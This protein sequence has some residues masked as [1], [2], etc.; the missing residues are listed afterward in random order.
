MNATNYL[1]T[2]MYSPSA[3]Q[4]IVHHQTGKSNLQETQNLYWRCVFCLFESSHRNNKDTF[5]HLLYVNKMPPATIDG[6]STVDLIRT[7]NIDVRM[8]DE[9][10]LP[11][12]GYYKAWS[13]QFVLL[14]ILR[15]MQQFVES[16][17][18]VVI[19]DSDV[20]FS[21]PVQ[22]DFFNDIDKYNSLLYTIDYP[23]QR[24]VNGVSL[25]EL[26]TMVTELSP[27]NTNSLYCEGGELICFKGA[28]LSR[29]LNTVNAGYQWSLARFEKGL[30][31]FNTEEH[32]FSYSYWKL[33]LQPFTGNKYLKRMWTDLSSAVNLEPGDERR[34]LWHLPAEKKHG[35]V[36]YFRLMGKNGNS[37][38]GHEQSLATMFRVNPSIRDRFAMMAR[39]PLK[40]TYKLIKAL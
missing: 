10:S 17:D 18:R 15:Q 13:S 36:R 40:K 23:V 16:H 26:R 39:I 3:E 5:K 38:A 14:D 19:L 11:P 24:S 2:W 28:I 25:E 12:K 6:I 21:K 20:I 1:V 34:M 37:L 33:G 27:E 8:I 4:N 31:K 22:Q 30:Q 35:F 29:L 7:F 9:R 32:L